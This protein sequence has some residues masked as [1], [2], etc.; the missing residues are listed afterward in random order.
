MGSF[1]T[2]KRKEKEIISVW[3]FVSC[4]TTC[5]RLSLLLGKDHHTTCFVW[6]LSHRKCSTT[7]ILSILIMT[8]HYPTIIC[9]AKSAHNFATAYSPHQWYQW[10]SVSPPIINDTSTVPH[11]SLGHQCILLAIT[12]HHHLS[13][14][15]ITSIS[16][17]QCQKIPD[18]KCWLTTVGIFTTRLLPR[19]L[20][21]ANKV[22]QTLRNQ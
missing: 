15:P 17:Q 22:T 3:L 2:T 12:T 13:S 19:H 8:K 5:S 18:I 20:R 6:I 7:Y 14:P 21:P 11:P 16:N 4:E 1:V 9:V 10:P